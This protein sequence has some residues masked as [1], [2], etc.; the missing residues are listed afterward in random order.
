ME[1]LHAY[2]RRE[3]LVSADRD[4]DPGAAPRRTVCAHRD[5]RCGNALLGL[6][7]IALHPWI[8]AFGVAVQM[9]GKLWSSTGWRCSMTMSSALAPEFGPHLH[10]AEQSRRAHDALV[11]V[12]HLIEEPFPVFGAQP[13]CPC[14]RTDRAPSSKPFA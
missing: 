8:T 1:R 13:V 3:V 4:A 2:P 5:K 12:D 11:C 14:C 9:F 7:L 6:G 10:E